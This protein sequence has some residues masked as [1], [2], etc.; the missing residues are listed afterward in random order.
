MIDLPPLIAM[1]ELQK[2]EA[3]RAA[4]WVTPSVKSIV[5]TRWP[6]KIVDSLQEIPESTQTL[7]AIGGGSLLDRA[8]IFARKEGRTIRLIAIPSIWGS[9]AEASKIAVLDRDGDKEIHLNA[10]LLPDAR[11]IWPELAKGVPRDRAL[12]ACGDAWSHAI[13]GFCSPLASDGL[14]SDLAD[15]MRKMLK[16]PLKSDPAW[17]E[18]SALACAGQSM[19][20][21]GLIHGI[22]HVLEHPLRQMSSSRPW[23][24]ARLCSVFLLPV[25][26][27]NGAQGEKWET[28][29]TAHALDSEAIF[30]VAAA[31]FNRTD[32]DLALPMLVTHW[33]SILRHSC[34]RTNSVL[35]RPNSIEFFQNWRA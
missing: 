26:S 13:E 29:C 34:T 2:L 31:L 1:E 8:K 15:V 16:I 27:F 18:L 21:V 12:H 25:L 4:A 17:F 5:A 11:V 7:V 19:S 28:L 32:Y 6:L 10:H 23:H 35:A 14:R 22:A 9:G 33:K 30:K 3:S 20:S 24:H